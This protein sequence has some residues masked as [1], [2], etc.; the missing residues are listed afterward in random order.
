MKGKGLTDFMQAGEA[1]MKEGKFTLAFENYDKAEQVAPNNPLIRLGRANAEL[2][3]SYYSRAE[4]H[5]HDVFTSHPELLVAQYDLTSMLG[6][7]RLKTLIRDLKELSKKD[8]NEPRP[9]FLLSY[10][11]YNTG[12]EQEAQGYLDLADKRAGGANPFYKLLR[13][14][15]SLPNKPAAPAAAPDANK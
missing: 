8:T 9:L 11:A 13:E 2:G 12:H 15:W 10:I 4:S 3:A 5:L 7:Q 14:N 1:A 6:E